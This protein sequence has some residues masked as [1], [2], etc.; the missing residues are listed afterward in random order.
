MFI[1]WT[2]L[3]K[4]KLKCCKV[5][6]NRYWMSFSDVRRYFYGVT[7]SFQDPLGNVRQ[8]CFPLDPPG[9]T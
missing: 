1:I 9:R 6:L 2:V 3:L 4:S 8:A 5:V 7:L